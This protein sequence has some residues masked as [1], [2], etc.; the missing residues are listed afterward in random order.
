DHGIPLT[1][2]ARI[3][4]KRPDVEI[5][6]YPDAGHGFHCDER[7]SYHQESAA[8]AWSRTQAFLGKHMK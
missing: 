3:K 1:D 8:L 4:E 7:G 6:T 2:V 5:Y